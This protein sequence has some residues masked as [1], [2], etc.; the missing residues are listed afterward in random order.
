M[1]KL[2]LSGAQKMLLMVLWMLGM[3]VGVVALVLTA[4]GGSTN[5]QLAY[6]HMAIA[7][8]VS[9]IFAM[10]AIRDCRARLGVGAAPPDV[11]GNT[12]RSMAMVWAWGAL[13]LFITYGTGVLAWK[14]WWPFFIAFT[15]AGGLCLWL[16]VAVKNSATILR[17]ARYL[18][19][20]QLV[21]MM[22]V[23]LGLLVDGKMVRFLNPR[24]TDWAA[25]NIFFFGA[26]ALAAIS[27]YALKA[28]RD[29]WR[30]GFRAAG[31]N[32]SRVEESKCR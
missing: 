31:T 27:G 20:T 14:E 3:A 30:V 13:M 10:L 26:L 29:A 25:N 18:A 7:A 21:G 2:D 4:A 22:V 17:W 11:A 1:L 6:A 5:L 23:M 19:L 12:A 9:T 32:L 15:V 8:T 28:N 24:Y 16:A